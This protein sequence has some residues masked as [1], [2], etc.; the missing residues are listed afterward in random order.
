M[1][2]IPVEG[3][4]FPLVYYPGLFED[5]GS[6]LRSLVTP[7]LISRTEVRQECFL[8]P[9][10]REYTYG[11]GRGARTYSSTPMTRE[12][13]EF[14]GK[15]G[16]CVRMFCPYSIH[17]D[18]FNAVFINQYLNDRQ[19]LGWPMRKDWTRPDE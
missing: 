15:V 7:M 2:T 18:P 19:H 5:Q 13:Q 12:L 1:K 17:Q 14:M 6:R 8:S 3:S 9:T 16:G 10:P 11:K 4:P